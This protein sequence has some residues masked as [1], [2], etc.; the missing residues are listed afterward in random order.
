MGERVDHMIF[1]RCD[2]DSQ[3]LMD[4]AIAEFIDPV[5]EEYAP[6]LLRERVNRFFVKTPEVRCF[7]VPALLRFAGEISLLVQREENNIVPFLMAG[8]I[9]QEIAC[10]SPHKGG[11]IN[12]AT[13]LLT[14]CGAGKNFLHQ[15]GCDIPP[16]SPH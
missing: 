1:H 13:C 12:E 4:F 7:Q 3:T 10:N 2:A 6:R 14:A 16:C 15:V 11:W 8:S 9:N 5:H